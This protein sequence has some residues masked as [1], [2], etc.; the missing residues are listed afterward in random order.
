MG[1]QRIAGN[2]TR[3]SWTAVVMI[4]VSLG[5]GCSQPVAPQT[6]TNPSAEPT[7][8]TPSS[9]VTTDA[10]AGK[11][12]PPAPKKRSAESLRDRI[13]TTV[14]RLR[15]DAEPRRRRQALQRVARALLDYRQQHGT[16]PAHDAN[17]MS[18]RVAILPFL[19]AEALAREFHRDELWDS[20]HNQS[21]MARMPRVYGE[22]ALGLTRLVRIG[23]AAETH[24]LLVIEVPVDAAGFWTSPDDG[25]V[26]PIPQLL[27]LSD[28]T[29]CAV[30]ASVSAEEWRQWLQTSAPVLPAWLQRIP[31]RAERSSII[32]GAVE[33][34]S[35]DAVH[36]ISIPADTWIAFRLQPRRLLLHPLRSELYRA[37]MSEDANPI[38][39]GLGPYAPQ[40]RNA[41]AWLQ[42]WGLALEQMESLTVVVPQK[43]LT[44]QF[45]V[46][47][48]FAVVCRAAGIFHPESL[49]ET[50]MESSDGYR[51][52]EQGASAGLVD[53]QRAF[54]LHFS[55]ERTLLMG[56]QSLVTAL[57]EARPEDSALTTSLSRNE[58]APFVLVANAEPLQQFWQREPRMVPPS[59]QDVQSLI[60][61]AHGVIFAIDP[62]ADLL[63]TLTIPFRQSTS[64]T[65]VQAI[66]LKEIDAQRNRLSQ[67][68]STVSRWLM[69]LLSGT[70]INV[71]GETLRVMVK[72]PANFDALVQSLIHSSP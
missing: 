71:E 31:S 49:I 40:L 51:Y 5:G 47:E 25:A 57:S 17:G 24:P 43:V 12:N 21:L 59:L 54:A 48:S 26:E 29:V 35:T 50:A 64:A 52:R 53:L 66:W 44:E 9:P 56:G 20:P 60:M 11:P 4:T 1:E 18:W 30:D 72:R 58:T 3:P 65:T 6:K 34:S 63:A 70:Q 46:N 27:A 41:V 42:Q 15:A 39:D 36:G 68:D 28:G 37:A 55:D 61:D 62:D 14:E 45:N 67:S 13:R 10:V 19:G 69:A 2:H 33:N 32:V 38:R 7:V 8:V 23:D 22:D 16:F